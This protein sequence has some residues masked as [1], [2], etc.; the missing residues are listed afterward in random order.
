VQRYKNI[1]IYNWSKLNY[2]HFQKHIDE[3]LDVLKAF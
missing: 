3:A 2:S 1:I